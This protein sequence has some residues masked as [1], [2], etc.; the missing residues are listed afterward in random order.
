MIKFS[1]LE[2]ITNGKILQIGIDYPVSL[3]TI[4]SRKAYTQQGTLFFAITGER[5]NGHQYIQELY[6]KGVRQFIVEEPPI[7]GTLTDAN[8]L[9]VEST[10]D[11]LQKIAGHHRSGFTLP[12]IGITGSNGK[13]IIKEWLYQILSRDKVV[14]KNPGSY[15]SQVGVPL[16]L[17]QIQ[18]YHQIGIFEAGISKPGEMAKLEAI[19]KPTVGIFTNIGTAHDE[20]FSEGTEKILEKITLFRSVDILIY[21]KD[22]SE[23]DRAV[24][25]LNIKKLSWGFHS[26]ADIVIRKKDSGFEIR[27][28]GKVLSF[29]FPFA[30]PASIENLLHCVV[31]L[32]HLGYTQEFIKEGIKG[33]RSVSMRLELK[34]GIHHCQVIDDTYN[35]DLGGLEISLQFLSHQ[36]QR[37]KKSLI[38]SDILESGLSAEEL[39]KQVA[40]LVSKNNIQ[41]FIGIGPVL[42]QYSN[43]FPGSN[44]FPDTSTFL[45]QFPFDQFQDEVILVKGARTFGFESIVNRLQRKVH[46]TVMEVNLGALIQN[47]NYFRSKLKP[48]T[49]I[50]VMVKAFAYGSGSNEVANILQYHKVDY[51]G[52]A[53]ADEGAELRKNNITLP[54]MVM[55]P[56]EESFQTILHYNLEPEVYSFKILRS[57]LR[58]LDRKKCW[59]HIKLDTGMHRLGFDENDLSELIAMLK[60]NSNLEVGSIFSHMAGADE[61]VH[62]AFSREQ[63][64]K[65]KSQADRISKEIG[66]RPIYHILNSPGILRLTDLQFDMVRLGVGLYGVDPTEERAHE[67]IPVAT[68]KTIIS[69][70]KQI[71][72][73]ESIGYGRKGFAEKDTTIATIAIGYADGYS[74]AFSRGAGNVLIHGRR[75]PVIGNVCMDMTMIDITGIPAQEGDEVIIFGAQ[76]P[77]QEVA[78]S[79]KTIPY[80]I[81]TNTSERVKRVF[82]AEGI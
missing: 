5:H 33:I 72:K 13:T 1:Q 26:S 78:D 59:I 39:S 65:F 35:N 9:Q 12:I 75:V 57:L 38:L 79:I 46:G 21:C 60:T 7:L 54:I 16:S 48:S 19:I 82:V 34:E 67:L 37:P 14:V 50:M 80:E 36:H 43:L 76:L 71:K 20:G 56:S 28:N 70:I 4:D 6:D 32:L 58:H 29:S 49:K 44:F 15:N 22:H 40:D 41:R 69:Q 73:G 11:A 64:L 66:Y 17:W 27:F 81:L 52:V 51:L 55:N 68:L 8:I 30:D 18:P 63:A 3:L 2:K 62:D 77:I 61:S 42:T 74:R 24:E 23:I 25:K 31:T 47:L 53:Y 45:A 10:V